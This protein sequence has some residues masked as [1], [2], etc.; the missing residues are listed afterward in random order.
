MKRC[1]VFVHYIPVRIRRK[2]HL[3]AAMLVQVTPELAQSHEWGRAMVH[4]SRR[5]NHNRQATGAQG[6]AE[7]TSQE[8]RLT[9]HES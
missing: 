7:R 6:I 3:E 4:Q 1:G 8:S 2:R 5:D 9:N